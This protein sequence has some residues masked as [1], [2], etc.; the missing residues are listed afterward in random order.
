MIFIF[1]LNCWKKKI[2]REKENENKIFIIL[3]D[4]ENK[5]I[6]YGERLESC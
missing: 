6:L 3:N 4:V 5:R 2:G 1:N